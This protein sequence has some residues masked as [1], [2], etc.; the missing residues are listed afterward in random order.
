MDKSKGGL[1]WP[2]YKIGDPRGRILVRAKSQIRYNAARSESR[3]LA[4]NNG[5]PAR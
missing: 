4:K 5:T 1:V 3:R 2:L